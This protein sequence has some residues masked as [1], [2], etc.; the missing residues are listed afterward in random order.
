MISPKVAPNPSS[1]DP[2]ACYLCG[3]SA[4]KIVV[5]NPSY[6]FKTCSA[7]GFR[8]QH[9]LPD[10]EEEAKLY[11]DDFYAVRELQLGLDEQDAMVRTLI[12]SRVNLLAELNG[13]RGSLLDVGAGTGL[14][15]EAARRAGWNATGIETS[16]A[17]VRI[18]SRLTSAPVT[19][20]RL[21]DVDESGVYDAVTM[22]D[23]LEH[24][25]DPRAALVICRRLLKPRGLVAISLPNMAG[26]KARMLG[27]RWRYY[28]REF[29]H[30]SHF[31]PRTLSELLRQSGYSTLVIRTA[32][33][34]N[35]GRPFGLQP[36][37]VRRARVLG[38]IQ[39][40]ADSAVGRAG[41]GEDLVAVARGV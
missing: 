29:G 38:A 28:R 10:P 12:D 6:S 4:I 26:F 22:W 13:G 8:M 11:D 34:F 1:A 20:R 7:C 5:A 3:S 35:L 30:L 19:Q 36:A 24:I 23:V 18:A 32:G 21:E 40:A 31:S 16:A 33:F 15:V 27:K 9:P 25:A 17:G 14:F 39:A 37:Q 41:M 2:R